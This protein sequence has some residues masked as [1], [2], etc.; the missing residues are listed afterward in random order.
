MV[1]KKIWMIVVAAFLLAGCA[2]GFK[3]IYDK[4]DGKVLVVSKKDWEGFQEYRG[5]V[6][7]TREGAFAVVVYGGKTEGWT[8][9]WCP[10]D[11]CYGGQDS[12]NRAM[13]SC[14]SYGGECLLF[15]TN[16]TILVNY[17]VEE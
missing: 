2:T 9:S 10:A 7:S 6:G 4:P 15:A 17:K 14:R 16:D 1:L 8:S 11:V 12:A 13:K 3:S 5:S